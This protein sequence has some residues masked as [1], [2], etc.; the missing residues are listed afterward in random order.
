MERLK[1]F[2]RLIEATDFD[3]SSKVILSL[4]LS[5]IWLFMLAV[6][7]TL[8]TLLLS[9]VISFD[10]W[11]AV[12]LPIFG[13]LYHK[14]FILVDVE[15]RPMSLRNAIMVEIN[16]KSNVEA[17]DHNLIFGRTPYIKLPMEKE[18]LRLIKRKFDQDRLLRV[19]VVLGDRP[20]SLEL[21][22]EVFGHGHD[23]RVLI[24]NRLFDMQS[25]TPELKYLYINTSTVDERDLDEIAYQV[26]RI[27]EIKLYRS[28]RSIKEGENA[29]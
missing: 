8:W 1:K 7:S 18:H 24:V 13:F 19:Q 5:T 10:F 20:S 16:K 25:A 26:N 29:E 23:T 21:F 14:L 2:A 17:R 15:S 27:N 6:L 4:I 9:Q 3:R 28:S 22:E 12:T 11:V